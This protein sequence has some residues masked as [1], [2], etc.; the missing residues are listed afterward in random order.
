MVKARWISMGFFFC[1]LA[2]AVAPLHAQSGVGEVR[3]FDDEELTIRSATK[4]EIPLSEAPGSVTLIPYSRIKESGART[5]PEVLRMAAG[6]DVRWNPMVQTIDIRGFGQNPFTSR[7]LLLIDGVPYN[8]WN[9]GGF[10]QHPGLDFFGLENVKQIEL[11]RG[12]GSALYGE[13]AFWGVINIVTLSGRDLEGGRIEGT[14]GD[15]DTET[16]K[17]SYGR[18]VGE[19]SIYVSAKA[20]RSQLPTKFWAEENDSQVRARD[21]FIKGEYKGLE[22]SYFRYEDELDGF[23]EEVPILIPG[24]PVPRFY[25]IPEVGQDVDILALKL[26][27]TWDEQ[28]ISFGGDLSYAQRSGSHCGACH[29]APQSPLFRQIDVDHGNQLI[30]DFRVGLHMIPSHD[31]LIGIETRKLDSGD[32]SEEL[33]HGGHQGEPILDYTKSALYVQDRISLMDDRLSLVIGARYDDQSDLFDSEVSPRI[34]A[35][36]RPQE[37]TVWRAGWNRAF[38]FPN[39]SELYQESWFFNADFGPFAAPIAAFIPN[40]GLQPE[41]IS[42]FELGLERRLRKDLSLKADLFH[43]D[44]D[45]FIV[46]AIDRAA[47]LGGISAVLVENHPSSVSIYGGELEL[48]WDPSP[49]INTLFSW[50]YRK[51]DPGSEGFDSAGQ[52]IEVVYAPENKLN[53]GLYLGPFSG[54]RAALEARWRDSRSTPSFWNVV[55][56]GVDGLGELPSDLV[57]DL[58]LS[59]ELPIRPGQRTPPLKI[60]VYGKDL[61]DEAPAETITGVDGFLVGRT[62]FAAVEVGF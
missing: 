33:G 11:L 14:Y 49:Q 45:D 60:S 16:L 23:S 59:Y 18:S 53:L 30:G 61:F 41:S 57:V 1:T 54:F 19:G 39:F 37:G 47:F 38:R 34:A 12:S 52:P 27:H 9:K 6:V 62:V 24:L 31:V 26:Q 48:K 55:S 32:H 58:R 2:M 36:F 42:S 4:T 40:P 25:S 56:T 13:N 7:V 43:N 46:T 10:P 28:Q 8:S 5:I 20:L 21:L 44:V 22:L 3:L 17:L 51:V 35:V 15:L 29:A 50:S